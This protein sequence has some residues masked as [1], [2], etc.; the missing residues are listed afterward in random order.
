MLKKNSVLIAL[1]GATIGKV[2]YLTFETTTNQNIAGLYPLN[3][4]TLKTKFLYFATMG[5]YPK[6]KERAGF[7]MANLSFI[8]NL[9]IPLPPLNEQEK[10][11]SCIENLET[12]ILNL[13]QILKE[14]QNKKAEIL[15]RY[16]F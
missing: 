16:L 1:V 2:G 11:S 12:Q 5:L 9:K 10:I 14:S 15:N 8:K 3:N 13:N 4:K 7:N 6:F